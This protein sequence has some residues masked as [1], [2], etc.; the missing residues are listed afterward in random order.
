[1]QELKKVTIKQLQSKKDQEKIS[2]ITAYDYLFASIFDKYVDVILVGDSLNMSF[3]GK[4]DTLDINLD[5]MIYH[6]KAVCAAS[7]HSFI[8]GDMPFGSYYN[9]KDA[10]KNAIRYYKESSI[11]AIKLEGGISKAALVKSITK[12]GIAV[13]A[14]IGLMPQ[15]GRSEGGYFVKGKSDKE[16]NKLLEDALALEDAG[17][18]LIV[19]EGVSSLVAQKITQSLSIPTIGIGA[20]RSCD[21]QILVWSDAFGFFTDFKPKFVRRFLNGRELL[22]KSVQEYVES[23]KNGSFPQ[24]V[25]SYK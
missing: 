14:H 10:L 9:T 17:A 2:C 6:S 23:V 8:I 5:S 22:E 4:K 16:A 11:D 12:E 19:L 20:G 24:D 18:S 15:F 25:E 3:N 13:V 21:G 1:M 7:T